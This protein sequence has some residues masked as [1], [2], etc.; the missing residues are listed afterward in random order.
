MN[1]SKHYV[2]LICILF[3][4]IHLFLTFILGSILGNVSFLCCRLIDGCRNLHGPAEMQNYLFCRVGAKCRG[5]LHLRDGQQRKGCSSC[6]VCFF[7]IAKCQVD[8][9]IYL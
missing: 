3:C 4:N 1:H 2:T 5:D 9:Q 6:A 7:A 8:E